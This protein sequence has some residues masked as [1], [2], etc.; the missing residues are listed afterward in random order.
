VLG[1]ATASRIRLATTDVIT[2]NGCL[3]PGL[4]VRK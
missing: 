3:G 4:A 1:N 2:A